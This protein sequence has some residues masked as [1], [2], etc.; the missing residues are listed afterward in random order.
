MICSNLFFNQ[1]I[2]IYIGLQW[3]TVKVIFSG[4]VVVYQCSIGNV[5]VTG[6]IEAL[7]YRK[8]NVVLEC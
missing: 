1:I 8:V 7:L 6:D 5:M 3:S 2:R 4:V